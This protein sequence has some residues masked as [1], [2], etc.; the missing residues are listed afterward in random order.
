MVEGEIPEEIEEL[1]GYFFGEEDRSVMK[2]PSSFYFFN[3]CSVI[4]LNS[5]LNME[6]KIQLN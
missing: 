3:Y 4:Y 2:R 6:F 1:G 5:R